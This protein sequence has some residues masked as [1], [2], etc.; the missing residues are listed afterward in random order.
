MA[1]KKS[2][3]IK[4]PTEMQ[5]RFRCYWHVMHPVTY[6]PY[7]IYRAGW[8]DEAWAAWHLLRKTQEEVLK[9]GYRWTYEWDWGN[10][11]FKPDYVPNVGSISWRVKDQY[12]TI[13][14]KEEELD[15]AWREKMQAWIYEAYRYKN[16]G[17]TLK[18]QLRHLLRLHTSYS[19]GGHRVESESSLVN[20]PAQLLAIWPELIAFLPPDDR[21]E[22]RGRRMR[23]SAPRN[24]T[25]IEQ[26][27]FHNV[28]R[29]VELNHALQTMALIPEEFDHDYP[30]LSP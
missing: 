23:F 10:K 29:M 8:T 28:P 12:P 25:P 14:I 26:R 6:D 7:K 15:E 1:F 5:A 17:E 24:W 30:A 3:R 19:S 11:I 27:D 21:D 13:T 9:I 20:T 2:F 22:M 16:L 18:Q 4:F